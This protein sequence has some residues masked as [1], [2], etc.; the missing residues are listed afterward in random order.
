MWSIVLMMLKMTDSVLALMMKNQFDHDTFSV[1]RS[2]D[3]EING[4]LYLTKDEKKRNQVGV[5][6]E[7]NKF[8]FDYATG[9]E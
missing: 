3:L 6:K 9:I 5:K 4:R 8:K 7:V 1:G 2:E